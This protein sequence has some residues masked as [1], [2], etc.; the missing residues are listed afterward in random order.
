MGTNY[1]LYIPEKEACEHCKRPATYIPSNR[2]HIGK[3]SAGWYFSLHVIPERGINDLIDWILFM[4][5]APP[6]TEIKDEYGRSVDFKSL[7]DVITRRYHPHPVKWS[8]S[9][10]RQN[11]AVQAQHGLVRFRLSP[12]CIGHGSGTWDLIVGDFS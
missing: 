6:G 4:T 3:S 12:H 8:Q 11:D 7:M 5:F 2:L 10:L 9:M 1:Y